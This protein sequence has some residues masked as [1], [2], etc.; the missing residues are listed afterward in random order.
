M[1]SKTVGFES[2]EVSHLH[3]VFCI[4][5]DRSILVET[6]EWCQFNVACYTATSTPET[7]IS[8]LS[9]FK[10]DSLLAFERLL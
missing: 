5:S 6:I 9:E 7:E 4:I 2:L 10:V 3:F 8:E 1:V